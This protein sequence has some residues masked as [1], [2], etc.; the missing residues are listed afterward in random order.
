MVLPGK[1]Y[2]PEDVSW[3]VWRRKWLVILPFLAIFAGT[4]VTAFL[5]PNRFRSE[6]LMLVVPQRVP[7][8]FVKS[9]VT[10][11]IED[12][13]RSI[14]Q[15]ILA[16]TNLEK[17]IRDADLYPS[18]RRGLPMEDVVELMRRDVQVEI[19][20]GDAFRVAYISQDPAKAKMVAESLGSLFVNESARDRKGL[21]NS[22]TVF[23][24]E[25]LN[26]ARR[27]LVD[28]EGK[29][30]DFQ[31]RY[32]GSLPADGAANL[33]VLQNLE[34][35][36]Q[37]LTDSTS[38]DTDRRLFLERA[39]ADLE[40]EAQDT[41]SAAPVSQTG[42]TPGLVAGGTPADQLEAARSALKSLELRLKPEHPDVVYLKRVIRDLEA[43]LQAE[44]AARPADPTGTSVPQASRRATAEEAN[45]QRRIREMR[46]ELAGVENQLASKQ[47]EA[48]RLRDQIASIHSRIAA[49]PA[50]AADFTALTRDYET[51]RNSYASLL[52]KYED[53]KA[54]ENLETRQI[55]EQFRTLDPARLPESPISPNRLLII[56]MGATAGLGV[57]LGLVALLE[58]KDK[59]LRSEDDVL[60]VLRL[61]VLAVIPV[62]ETRLDLAR[63]KRRRVLAAVSGLAVVIVLVGATALAWTLGYLRLP[64]MFR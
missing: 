53:A 61:P 11:R 46:Q 43:K 57:G 47:T 41:R 30:A 64:L 51:I 27:R 1:K 33:Q 29:V 21:A 39:L 2:T 48:K 45:T 56:L 36:V 13:L 31:R 52:A 37:A 17:I 54:A 22:T 49:T 5:L 14:Q 55:G 28:A 40:A 20:R 63:R 19:V 23:L 62:I 7:E 8:S 24:E 32:A 16:R 25:Q 58:Q 34:M 26:D 4:T 44:G 59:G 9:T 42:D 3:M 15:Q 6:T 50:L 12:R 10:T 18:E 60:T 35:Q 38:R